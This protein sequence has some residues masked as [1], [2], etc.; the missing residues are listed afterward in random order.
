MIED[1]QY[2]I[3][4]KNQKW[5]DSDKSEWLSQQDIKRSYTVEVLTK[6]DALRNNFD[7]EQYGALSYSSENYPLFILK[8]RQWD[9]NKPF[10]LITG[11]VHGYETSGVQGALRFLETSAEKYS[12]NFNILVAPCVSPWGYETINRW[13][14]SCIDPNRSFNSE[15]KAEEALFLMTYLKNQKLDFLVHIDLH[16]TTDTD[17]SEFRPALAAKDNIH[18]PY[19]DIPDGLYLVGDSEKPV[20]AFQAA[21]IEGVKKIT[22]IAPSDENGEII[23]VKATQEGVINYE[24]AKLGLATGM[25]DCIY[26][27]TTEVYP[28]S[29]DVDDEICIQAQ[30]AAVCSGLDYVIKQNSA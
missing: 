12:H 18:Q 16:E 22:H 14:P 30:V 3:G 4:T 24:I 10:V 26:S 29:E 23:G 17:N 28:D 6:I 1:Q 8:T 5:D 19:W 11:G 2:P 25:T 27:T 7:I 21:I 13:N 20:D 15:G 9:N